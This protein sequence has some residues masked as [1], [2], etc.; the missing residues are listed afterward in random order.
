MYVPRQRKD[1]GDTIQLVSAKSI[2]IITRGQIE[3]ILN[4]SLEEKD[5][6]R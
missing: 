2:T 5:Y 6:C 1:N 3:G 4:K